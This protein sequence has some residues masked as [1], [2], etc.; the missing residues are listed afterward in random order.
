MLFDA[1]A[2]NMN[3]A[4]LSFAMTTL[5]N[6]PTTGFGAVIVTVVV[7]VACFQLL[8]AAWVPV[9]VMVPASLSVRVEPE[10]VAIWCPATV[11]LLNA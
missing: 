7:A 10:R 3:D 11:L 6:V 5:V 8:V 9:R 4:T 1:G 2:S